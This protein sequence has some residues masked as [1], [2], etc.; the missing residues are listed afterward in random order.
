LL[1][2]TGKMYVEDAT[3]ALLIAEPTDFGLKSQKLPKK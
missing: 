3:L 1:L 2:D